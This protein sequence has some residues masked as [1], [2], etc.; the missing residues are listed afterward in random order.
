TT[1]GG[2]CAAS[3]MSSAP[4]NGA[5]F[6]FDANAVLCPAVGNPQCFPDQ[7][8][9]A[10]DPKPSSNGSDQ[11]YLVYRHFTPGFGGNCSHGSAFSTFPS[12]T[13]SA[14][15]GKAWLPPAPIAAGDDARV[16]VGGDGFVWV[17]QRS[18]EVITVSKFS[19]CETGLQPQPGFP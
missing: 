17:V 16:T 13:C 18:Y 2:A 3:V 19:S 6:T 12:I 8:H 7:E 5:A 1:P 10:A 14:D 4:N 9:I 15:N 11:I